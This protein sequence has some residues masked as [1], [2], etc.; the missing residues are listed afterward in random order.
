MK[1]MPKLIKFYRAN[2]HIVETSIKR[3]KEFVTTL[4][5]TSESLVP[6]LRDNFCGKS[7]RNEIPLQI[8]KLLSAN[9]DFKNYYSLSMA[10]SNYYLFSY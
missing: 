3:P 7:P 6:K 4:N 10:L 2:I 1:R 8:H 5:S 9:A